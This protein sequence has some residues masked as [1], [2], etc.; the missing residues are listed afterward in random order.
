MAARP[1]GDYVPRALERSFSPRFK[2]AMVKSRSRRGPKHAE[3]TSK[4]FSPEEDRVT[5]FLTVTWMM[6]VVTALICELGSVASTW[7]VRLRPESGRIAILGG[8]LTFAAL[9]IGLI[10][11]GLLIAVVRR[12]QVPPPLGIIVFATVVGAAPLLAMLLR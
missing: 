6:T 11:L 1:T 8:V 10:S 4:R 2:A 3:G 7:F 5:E 9:V 12:R